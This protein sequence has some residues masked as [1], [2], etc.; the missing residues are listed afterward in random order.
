MKD[1]QI[2]IARY[3][4][5]IG[6]LATGLFDAYDVVIYNKGPP[7]TDPAIV[8]RFP[9]VD[10]PNVGKIDHTILWHIIQNYGAMHPATL[11]TCAGYRDIQ[12]KKHRTEWIVNHLAT[13]GPKTVLAPWNE[14]K[15]VVESHD[16]FTVCNY[17]TAHASNRDSDIDCKTQPAAVRPFGN[18]YRQVFGD[19]KVQKLFLWSIFAVSAEDVLKN[20]VS[21]YEEIISYLDSH[22]NPEAGHYVERCWTTLF[23]A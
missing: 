21:K 6:Y 18:W 14:A 15:P 13:Q 17:S 19:V 5:D 9:I 1:I 8:G 4:E 11:F 20:P 23:H 22:P 3:K 2:V 10:L 16:L 12:H 7:I